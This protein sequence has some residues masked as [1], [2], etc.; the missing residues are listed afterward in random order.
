MPYILSVMFYLSYMAVYYA[1]CSSALCTCIYKRAFMVPKSFWP[2]LVYDGR[3]LLCFLRGLCLKLGSGS[4][5][6]Y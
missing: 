4:M 5:S 3:C 1:N 2:R 6:L